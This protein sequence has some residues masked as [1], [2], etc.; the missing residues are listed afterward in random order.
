LLIEDLPVLIEDLPAI[1]DDLPAVI[2]EGAVRIE[3]DGD[4]LPLAI[5]SV[6]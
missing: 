6:I 4:V 3:L 1:T 2:R 5:E